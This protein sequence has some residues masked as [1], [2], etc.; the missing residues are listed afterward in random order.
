MPFPLGLRAV[1]QA[2][3]GGRHVAL[4]WAVN[5]VMSV[6]GSAGAVAVAM[7]AGFST[8]LFVG[9]GSY[10]IAAGVAYLTSRQ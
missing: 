8:V 6:V 5:G 3:Q 1:G 9:A 7:L 2:D 10:L 4:A